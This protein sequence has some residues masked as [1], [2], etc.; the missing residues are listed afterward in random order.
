[1]IRRR[2]G[3]WKGMPAIMS[4]RSSEPFKARQR[5]DADCMSL[6]TIARHAFLVPLPLAL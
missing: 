2:P 3:S 1:M 5:F 4:A 6:K